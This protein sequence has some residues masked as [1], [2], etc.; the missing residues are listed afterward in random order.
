MLYRTFPPFPSDK[1]LTG[2]RNSS[3]GF[4]SS[5]RWIECNSA[6]SRKSPKNSE[7]LSDGRR[8]PFWFVIPEA[9]R[10]IERVRRVESIFFTLRDHT[11]LD[12]SSQ[13]CWASF[14]SWSLLR[15]RIRSRRYP[16][17][18]ETSKNASWIYLLRYF[19]TVNR[20]TYTSIKSVALLRP[21]KSTKML[22]FKGVMASNSILSC[23]VRRVAQSKG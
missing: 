8:P 21:V 14:S 2:F 23:W 18:F 6:A 15:H 10:R 11:A 13:G 7:L 20:Q 17:A 3:I 19:A 22:Q 9:V 4:V 1:L 5:V 12:R 16:L